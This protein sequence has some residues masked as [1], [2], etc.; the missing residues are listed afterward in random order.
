VSEA[1][2][3]NKEDDS[4]VG[5][6]EDGLPKNEYRDSVLTD[7]YEGNSP[8]AR[9]NLLFGRAGAEAL[10]D[11][12]EYEPKPANHSSPSQIRGTPSKERA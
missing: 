6:G 11:R 3:L 2:R 10:Y 9:E 4:P 7:G 5:I 12:S 8:A 1:E